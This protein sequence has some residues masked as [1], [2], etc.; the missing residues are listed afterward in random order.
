MDVDDL[1]AQLDDTLHTSSGGEKASSLNPLAST[2]NVSNARKTQTSSSRLTPN[3]YTPVTQ[4]ITATEGVTDNFDVDN[5]LN[6]LDNVTSES[7]I[8]GLVSQVPK[9]GLVHAQGNKRK[10]TNLYVGGSRE[11]K[12]KLCSNIRCTSCD[13]NVIR[14]KDQ[15]WSSNVNYMFFRNNC[16][17]LSRLQMRLT[18][19][20]GY[21]AYCCQCS[22]LNVCEATDVTKLS[23]DSLGDSSVSGEYRW[24]CGGH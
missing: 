3:S 14:I 21:S 20:P 2:S 1:L 9:V 17:N 22:W 19:K 13:F 5:L 23:R 6:M 15:I 16:P 18:S 11:E 8:E 10:C 24:C 4:N 12:Q 7:K